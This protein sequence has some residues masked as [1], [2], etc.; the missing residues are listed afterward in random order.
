MSLTVTVW[1]ALSPPVPCTQVVRTNV[2]SVASAMSLIV[3]LVSQV[4]GIADHVPSL[5]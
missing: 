4:A 3:A 5:T 1:W 2:G